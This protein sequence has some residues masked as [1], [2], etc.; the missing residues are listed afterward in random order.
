MWSMTLNKKRWKSWGKF[1]GTLLT[2]EWII[3]STIVWSIHTCFLP[4][5]HYKVVKYLNSLLKTIKMIYHFIMLCTQ[6]EYPLPKM[7]RSRS[8]S[9]FG[10]F[11]ILEHCIDIT[12][13][14]SLIWNPKYLRVWN[15]LIVMLA[16][17]IFWIL[18]HF[19]FL[20]KGCSTHT[21]FLNR[22]SYFQITHARS[23]QASGF[24]PPILVIGLEN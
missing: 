13:W 4:R 10:F 3:S 11:K 6:V 14:T 9:N 12:G 22:K 20:D 15:F 17:K 19:G 7:R 2:F 24:F 1:L 18:E 5:R 8:V 16:H 21:T 23:A